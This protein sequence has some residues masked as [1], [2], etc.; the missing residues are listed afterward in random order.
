MEDLKLVK[1]AK[2]GTVECDIY[3]H[4]DDFLMTREQIGRALG[5]SDPEVAITKIHTKY[6]DRLNKFSTHTRLVR[7]E[8]EREVTRDVT[9]YTAKGIYE[10]CRWSRQPKA[11]EFYDYI[12]NLLEGLR[13][14]RLTISTPTQA[15]LKAVEILAEQEKKL[16]RIEE[17]QQVLQHRMDNM[18]ALDTIGDPQQ[19]LN[20]M[21]RKYAHQRGILFSIAWGHFIEAFNTAY[22]TNLRLLI[23]NHKT[24]HDLRE[25]TTPQYL[26]A[27][28]K[29]EDAIRVADKMLNNE[30][31]AGYGH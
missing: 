6:G 7:V 4:G 12:Y 25:I 11:H 14:H 23:S 26:A 9:L 27:V 8:G 22:H 1:S 13:T 21:V 30:R 2:F 29:L 24:K 17:R 16:L 31:A 18:D 10:I 3:S 15:L 5:Y 20:A 28:G 19:R